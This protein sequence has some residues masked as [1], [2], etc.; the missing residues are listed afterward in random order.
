MQRALSHVRYVLWGARARARR[1]QEI[2][3]ANADEA[4]GIEM[5]SLPHTCIVC[6][7]AD[8]LPRP[9]TLRPCVSA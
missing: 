3:D 4:V 5:I 7:V 2:L 6:S 9:G 1:A 8:N